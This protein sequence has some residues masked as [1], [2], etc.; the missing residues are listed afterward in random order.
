MKQR[1][2][3]IKFPYEFD[4][5]KRKLAKIYERK[6]LISSVV[7]GIIIQLAFLAAFLLAGYNAVLRDALAPYELL[8]LPLYI[9]IFISLTVIVGFPISF[10]SSYVYDKKQGLVVQ[11]LAGWFKDFFKSLALGYVVTVPIFT[12]LYL[13]LPLAGWWLYAG[14][15]YFVL[16]LFFNYIV[17]IVVFPWFY[18]TKPYADRAQIVKLKALCSRAGV[19][20][21]KILVAKESERSV[22]ANAMF[23]GFGRTKRIVLFDTLTGKFAPPEIETVVAHELG[24]YVNR[25]IWRGI[26]ADAL[27]VFPVLFVVDYILRASV[28]SLGLSSIADIASFPLFL[29]AY[30]VLELIVMPLANTYWRHREAQADYFAISS[31]RKPDANASADRRLADIALSNDDPHPVIEFIFDNHPSIKKRVAMAEEWK[32]KN[33]SKR[34]SDYDMT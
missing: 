1:K 9:L 32:R 13:I 33:A 14:A 5:K 18:K 28:G 6:K 16:I 4:P 27:K 10:W 24:H 34:K 15:A 19:S 12:G 26:A 3:R 7:N 29:L 31:T 2:A 8:S 21:S 17:P 22:R 30:S 23:M 20:I 25:D 11:K